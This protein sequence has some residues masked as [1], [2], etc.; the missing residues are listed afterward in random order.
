MAQTVVVTA[1]T[2]PL[3]RRV[4]ER[5][6]ADPGVGRVIAVDAAPG[7]A[8]G[9]IEHHVA[10][11]DDP[12]M[13]AWCQGASAVIH[14]GA[15]PG[16]VEAARAL[17]LTAHRAGVPTLV[18]LSSATVYGA[19]PGNPV[20]LTEAAPLRPVPALAYAVER[21]EVERLA[22]GWRDER[23]A[24]NGQDAPTVAVL[25]PAITVGPGQPPSLGPT[26]WPRT[27]SLKL[28]DE[29]PAQF[30]HLD[31][32]AAAVDLARRQRLDGPYNVAPDG[33]LSAEARRDLQ[34]P[35]PR[36]GLPVAVA[37]RIVAL[38]WRLG[39]TG[40]P[41]G[42]LPYTMCPWVVANDRLKAAGWVPAHT[43]E[44]AFVEVDPGGPLTRSDPRR[45]Q[46]L[47]LAALAIPLVA[48]VGAVT[49][50]VLRRL[51]RLRR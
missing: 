44:E 38:R 47:S 20:P 6:A 21:A 11:L 4:C 33:W 37:E 45:R 13:K 22:A 8:T 9:V 26:P 34:G 14:L 51:R 12:E 49:F 23:S 24:G 29:A 46:L 1:A 28:D 36:L 2:S 15:G 25:R 32:V 5:A 43:N 3:G 10:A 48:V 35:A 42:V 40:V 16:D 39:L 30:V 7:A 41:P 17:L 50:V 19:W 31:D 18:V 27:V